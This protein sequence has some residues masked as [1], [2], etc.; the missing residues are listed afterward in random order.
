MNDYKK[1]IMAIPS[2]SAPIQL[3]SNINLKNITYFDRNLSEQK[4]FITLE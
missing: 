3:L 2:Q 4:V 1:Y